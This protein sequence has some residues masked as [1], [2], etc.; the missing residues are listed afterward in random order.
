MTGVAALGPPAAAVMPQ[1]CT[2]CQAKLDARPWH[3][4]LAVRT[5]DFVTGVRV[6]SREAVDRLEAWLG[7]LRAPDLDSVVSPNFSVELGDETSG[8][9]QL[10]LVYR[11][12]EIV[13]RRRDSDEALLDL[14]FLLDEAARL[15]I[16]DRPVALA[17]GVIGDSGVLLVPAQ[18][19][20]TLL[21]RRARLEEAGLQVLRSRTQV[22]DPATGE[23]E[24]DLVDPALREIAN[25][26]GQRWGRRRLGAWC[27]HTPANQTNDLSRAAG[28]YAVC[29]TVLNRY[30]IGVGPVLR[31]LRALTE[32]A[33]MVALPDL[34][35]SALARELIR[36]SESAAAS[37]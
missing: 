6:N 37:S 32:R 17:S 26:A 27:V 11:D 9:R 23:V 36:L 15:S 8:R 13:A 7:P 16:L 10:H 28:I 29:P 2:P 31:S 14:T 19:H 25:E 34:G 4:T 3:S 33:R 21:V 35:P 18:L 12:S 22:I 5:G 24:L 1:V 20:T 30:T